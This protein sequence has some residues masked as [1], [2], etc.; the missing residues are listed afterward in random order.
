MPRSHTVKSNVYT[1]KQPWTESFCRHKETEVMEMEQVNI[2]S[3]VTVPELVTKSPTHAMIR[4][5]MSSVI[6]KN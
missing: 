5:R 1:V 2:T 3:F 6:S 4:D